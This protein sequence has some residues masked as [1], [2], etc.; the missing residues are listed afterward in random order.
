MTSFSISVFALTL[1]LVSCGESPV[2]STESGATEGTTASSPTTAELTEA[3]S[4][5]DVGAMKKLE[6]EVVKTAK[7]VEADLKQ[8]AAG[9]DEKAQVS[10]A[11]LNGGE[12]VVVKL[13]EAGNSQALFELGK[14]YN[15]MVADK[16]EL[17]RDW[18]IKAADLGHSEAMFL[19]GKHSLHGLTGFEQDA[20]LGRG[21]LEKAAKAGDAEAAFTLGVALRYGFGLAEDK[22]AALGFY[23]QAQA[24]GFKD[25]G[26]ELESLEKELAE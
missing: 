17:G 23:Q 4:H 6:A 21:Y 9:G 26:G 24:G 11:W 18:L 5:G 13:A 7:K 8:A 20:A 22:Q 16:Q 15:A 3:A 14:H 1:L 25:S 12:S 19:V 10:S 2:P